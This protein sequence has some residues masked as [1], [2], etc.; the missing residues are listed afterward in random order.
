MND[1][2][3]MHLYLIV[4]AAIF[5]LIARLHAWGL[6]VEGGGVQRARFSFAS[7]IAVALAV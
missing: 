4:T 7:V 2:A 5:V 6:I 3:I 1:E